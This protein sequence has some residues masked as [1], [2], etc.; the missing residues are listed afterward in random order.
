MGH[1]GKII[2]AAEMDALTP[3]KSY[4]SWHPGE[5]K[6][7]KRRFNKRQR[8]AAKTELVHFNVGQTK[9]CLTSLVTN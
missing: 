6:K 3:W 4:H 7:I 1:R 5:R 8:K 9:V 2:I